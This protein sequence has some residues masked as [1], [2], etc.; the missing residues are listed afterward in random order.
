MKKFLLIVFGILFLSNVSNAQYK[1]LKH[2]Y[3]YKKYVYQQGDPYNPS[4]AGVASFFVPGLGQM[5][6]DEVNR[7]LAFLGGTAG[8]FTIY[9][10][11]IYVLSTGSN[12]QSGVGVAMV[13]SG[14]LGALTVNIWAIVDAVHVAKVRNMAFRDRNKSASRFGISPYFGR[15]S[16]INEKR[17]LSNGVTMAWKF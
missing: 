10:G 6:S 2:Q 16:T 4:M 15:L 17:F 3:D 8:F 12:N 7:G 1:V 11:G 9:Y 13:A 14:L 5:L